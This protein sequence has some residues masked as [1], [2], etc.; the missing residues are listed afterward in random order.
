MNIFSIV[1]FISLVLSTSLYAGTKCHQDNFV[2]GKDLYKKYE[3]KYNIQAGVYDSLSD[4]YRKFDFLLNKYSSNELS[5]VWKLNNPTLVTMLEVQKEFTLDE[6]EK[7]DR[8]KKDLKTAKSGLD[9]SRRLWDKLADYCYNDD[10]YE[11]Y[12]AARNNMRSSISAIKLA[13]DL[14]DKIEEKRLKYLKEVGLINNA[15]KLHEDSAP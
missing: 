3:D 13:D 14:L 15:E 9:K 10:Y 6:I 7:I 12:K 8:F 1:C 11:S 4:T 5:K 2:V